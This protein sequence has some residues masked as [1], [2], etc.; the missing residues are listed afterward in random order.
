MN[1]ADYV[2]IRHAAV[3][4]NPTIASSHQRTSQILYNT[5]ISQCSGVYW[6]SFCLPGLRPHDQRRSIYGVTFARPASPA[7]HAYVCALCVGSLIEG[8]LIYR[9]IRVFSNNSGI[10]ELV[11]LSRLSGRTNQTSN[12]RDD[13]N[14]SPLLRGLLLMYFMFRCVGVCWPT[15]RWGLIHRFGSQTSYNI[16]T[17]QCV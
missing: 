4:V 6:N 9:N 13:F 14:T 7:H 8:V 15:Q 5:G 16:G 10:I 17:N 1:Y 2:Y 12:I 3:L 11:L